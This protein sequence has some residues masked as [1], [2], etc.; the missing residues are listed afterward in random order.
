LLL[1]GISSCYLV[2]QQIS[3][4]N[5]GIIDDMAGRRPHVSPILGDV[6]DRVVPPGAGPPAPALSTGQPV[7][8]IAHHCAAGA[9][10]SRTK[11]G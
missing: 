6:A 4:T 11:A 9:A 2:Q 3:N 8:D 1:A 10:P 5:R 7:P